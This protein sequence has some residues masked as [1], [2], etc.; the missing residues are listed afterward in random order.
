MILKPSIPHNP[1]VLF[2]LVASLLWMRKEAW[3]RKKWLVWLMPSRLMLCSCVALCPLC[4]GSDPSHLP[5]AFLSFRNSYVRLRHLCTNTWVTSTSIPIDTDEERP[6]MLKVNIW[7][8]LTSQTPSWSSALRISVLTH[9]I[10]VIARI[11]VRG[12]LTHVKPNTLA[13]WDVP[14]KRGQGSFCYC[15]CS[16]VW[17]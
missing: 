15:L 9:K 10:P 6:V 3:R 1:R 13:D 8:S 7:R 11:Q 17:G 16:S 12:L 2:V 5:C 4:A 14:N